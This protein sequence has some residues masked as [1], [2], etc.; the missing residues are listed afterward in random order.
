MKDSLLLASASQIL[1]TCY[2]QKSN[3]PQG[4]SFLYKALSYTPKSEVLNTAHISMEISNTYTRLRNH[5]KAKEFA[6][7]SIEVVEN[8]KDSTTLATYS[9]YLSSI[10]YDLGKGD[11][12][13]WAAEKAFSIA[14]SLKDER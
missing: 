4:L 1:G 10:Y 6:T 2:A 9:N 14:S 12:A 7:K 3:F 8:Q 13:L 5:I 11:S